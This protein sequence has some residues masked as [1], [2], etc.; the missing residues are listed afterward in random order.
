MRMRVIALLLLLS[1]LAGGA[2]AQ[3]VSARQS[4]KPIVRS[5]HTY[6]IDDWSAVMHGIIN[7]TGLETSW[8]SELG[9]TRAY[10]LPLSLGSREKPLGG[11]RRVTVEEA[12]NCLAPMTTYHF[13][14]V[15]KNK[16]GKT[17]G[18]DQTFTTKRPQGSEAGV[19]ERCPGHE[20]LG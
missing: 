5:A 3:S 6:G 11:S 16:A 13:R 14:I 15:A 20:P 9:K 12:I 1:A 10:G 19:Y 7:P 17:Y 8:R 18:P 4:L 2:A